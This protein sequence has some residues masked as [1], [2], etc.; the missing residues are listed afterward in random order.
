MRRAAAVTAFGLLMVS[1]AADAAPPAG[2]DF[3]SAVPPGVAIPLAAEVIALDAEAA[4]RAFA[5]EDGDLVLTQA[6]SS[7]AGEHVRF[8]VLASDG[9][10][11]A[12]AELSVHMTRGGQRWLGR[13]LRTNVARP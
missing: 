4:A 2:I 6:R 8:A 3:P 1:R 11:V 12:G 13:L 9:T 7:L 10:R 5:G